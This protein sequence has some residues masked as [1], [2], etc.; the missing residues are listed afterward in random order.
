MTKK[1]EKITSH[2][3][4]KTG[5]HPSTNCKV[6]L[7]LIVENLTCGVL[8]LGLCQMLSCCIGQLYIIRLLL[9]DILGSSLEM[10][11]WYLSRMRAVLAQKN[12]SICKVLHTPSMQSK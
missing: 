6:T 7:R 5:M 9:S 10:F 2:A 1:C 11:I 8:F 4:S 12:L 3:K